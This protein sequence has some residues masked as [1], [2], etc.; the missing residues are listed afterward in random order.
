MRRYLCLILALALMLSLCACGKKGAGSAPESDELQQ[1][2]P[3]EET[4]VVPTPESW[5][6]VPPQS[7]PAETAPATPD[8]R[9]FHR[10][11]I[12]ADNWKTYF[13]LREI[14]LYSITS[15]G[16]IAQVYQTY[17]VVLRDE[18]LDQVDRDGDYSVSFSF[19]F[20]LYYNT[21]SVDTTDYHYGHTDDIMYEVTATKS[22]VFDRDAL[23]YSA[24]GTDHS[25]YSGYSN[26]FFNGWATIHPDSKVWSGFYIQLD[27][28]QLE[29]VEGY[30][31]LAD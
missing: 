20:D 9:S 28:V 31:E 23:P 17:C 13:Q 2:Q 24:Y 1:E 14:P 27:K 16:V 7:A 25:R 12:T 3:A 8:T 5:S 10:V 6:A 19:T 15:S 26:A 11:E 18:Y 4:P 30:L 22:A 21:L 29:S